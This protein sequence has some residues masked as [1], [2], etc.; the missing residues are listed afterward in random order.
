MTTEF[1]DFKNQ[2]EKLDEMLSSIVAKFRNPKMQKAS[3]EVTFT[4]SKILIIAGFLT[5][6]LSLFSD[7]LGSYHAAVGLA[8][9]LFGFFWP[10]I[11]VKKSPEGALGIQSNL[12]LDTQKKSLEYRKKS[13]LNRM[14]VLKSNLDNIHGQIDHLSATSSQPYIAEEEKEEN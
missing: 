1:N 12:G 4:T 10:N 5:I 14:K 11:E 6:G 3:K 9:T 7:Y 8:L 2:I 13:I